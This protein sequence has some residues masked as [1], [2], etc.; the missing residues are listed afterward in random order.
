MN[1]GNPVS[2]EIDTVSFSF[3]SADEVKNLSVKKIT[4]PT[5]FDAMGYPVTNGLYDM[6]LGPLN[7]KYTCKTC[8]LSYHYCPGHFGHIELATP[9]YNVIL[10]KVMYKLLQSTCYCCHKLRAP[11]HTLHFF[12]SKLK[13]IHAGLVLEAEELGLALSIKAI[14]SGKKSYGLNAA[15][16]GSRDDDG[17]V[18][19]EENNDEK[20]D[21]PFLEPEE[22]IAAVD[23]YVAEKFV[24][25]KSSNGKYMTPIKTTLVTDA[26][27]KTEKQLLA[28][29]SSDV[30]PHCR[31]YSPKL[32]SENMQKIF[33]KQI[34]SKQQSQMLARNVSFEPIF[35]NKDINL[36]EISPT[37]E[38]VAERERK[39]GRYIS[40]FEV[41]AHL[42]LLW[43][44]ER[45]ILDLMFGSVSFANMQARSTPFLLKK[46][47]LNMFFVEFLPV[48]PNKFRPISQ[49]NDMVYEHPQNF[50]LSA[51]LRSNERIF[52]LKEG[53]FAVNNLDVSLTLAAIELQGHVNYLFDSAK[54]P[55]VKGKL[56]PPGIRQLLEKKE[57]LFRQNMM[58]KR[59]NYAARSVISPDNNIETNEIGIPPAFAVKLTYPER[60]TSHNY[61]ELARMI[62]N[63][64]HRWPGATH[65]EH[66]N[67]VVVNLELV[68]EADRIA[69]ANSILSRNVQDGFNKANE[70][71]SNKVVR[72][73]L[74]NGDFLLLNRQPTLHKP[75][76][77]AHTARVLPNEK[78]IRMHYANC[79][80]YNAD[81]DGDEMNIHFP[82]ND[83]GRA[84]AMLI[85]R[86]DL[87]YLVPTDGGV[88][89]GLIQDHVDAGVHLTS[90]DTWLTRAQYIQLIY[91][92]LRP[93]GGIGG[94]HGTRGEGNGNIEPILEYGD[95]NGRLLTLEPAMVK[96][97]RM[98]SGKQ[99]I[100]TVLL[101]LT[102]KWMPLNLVG[103]SRVAAKYWG[104]TAPE[105]QQV[106]FCDGYLTTGILD[107]NQFGAS[108]YGLVHA[109]YE[110]Y[111]PRYAGDLLSI[112]GRLF[113]AFL[114]T[115][116]F[117]CRMDDLRLTSQGDKL[118]RKALKNGQNFGENAHRE[119]FKLG[120]TDEVSTRMETAIR[121]DETMAGLDGSMK[122]AMNGLTSDIIATCIPDHLLRQF[123]RNN[124]QTMTVS[125]AKGSNVNVSQISC[126]LGQQELEGRRVPI[127]VSGKSLPSFAPFETAARA[128][129]F[130]S[131][132]FL[133][134]I[135]P[136]E[137][138]FH[139]MAGR[140]GL[141]DTAVKTSRSGYLQRCLI[142]HLEGLRVHYDHTVRDEDGSVYQFL[143]GEDG[144][145]VAL[146]KYLQ[147]FQFS[148]ANFDAF[149]NKLKI[150]EV[151][152]SKH[153]NLNDALKLGKKVSK[154]PAKYDPVISQLSPSR[155]LG[156]A[157]ESFL[158][159]LNEYVKSNPDELTAGDSSINSERYKS[160][161]ILR[162]LRSLVAP[163]EA[164]GL[165]AAQSIGEPSTQMTL[166]TFHFAG[167]GAK[168]VTLGI[169]RLREIIM[170]ASDHIKTP[171]MQL[172]LLPTVGV[173]QAKMI[174]RDLSKLVLSQIV[175]GIKVVNR[176]SC[177]KKAGSDGLWKQI[178]AVRLDL[179][180]ST[181]I[182]EEY[183]ITP[184][185]LEGLLKARF[186]V[187]LEQLIRKELKQPLSAG[188][189]S[190]KRVGKGTDSD[191]SAQ[192]KAESDEAEDAAKLDE[193]Y[194][195]E[196]QLDLEAESQSSSNSDDG[197]SE[198][199]EAIGARSGNSSKMVGKMAYDA[200]DSE[201]EQILKNAN[202]LLNANDDFLGQVEDG[203]EEDWDGQQKQHKESTA[204]DSDLR[205][206]KE[207]MEAGSKVEGVPFSCYIKQF[208][209]SAK[210][211][212]LFVQLEIPASQKKLLMVELA[213][214]ACAR[215]VLHQ[216][217][218][219]EKSYLA[220]NEIESDKELKLM[221]EG[222]N[223]AGMWDMFESFD[224]DRIY[225]N[226]I[227]AVLR[228]FGVEAA[229]G[230]IVREIASVFGVYGIQVDKRHLS[231]IADYMTFEGAYK[232]FNRMGMMSNPSPFTQMSYET[233]AQFLTTATLTG[234]YDN[235]ASPS[236]RIVMGKVVRG[237][238]GSFQ[239]YQP[240][241]PMIE[242]K[243]IHS[244]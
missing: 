19:D 3:Y 65:V 183:K 237:G 61:K 199:E 32:R 140:E 167:F 97:R 214:K 117:T 238:T 89:R 186:A 192:R 182:L 162:Y 215:T 28:S 129:G 227:A 6:A 112:L 99:V 163:G 5:L 85:A 55:M 43:T 113:T 134:G 124:M 105:E 236:A 241:K 201:D 122:S 34:T 198:S 57:G 62:V 205:E 207:L 11:R 91:A 212:S 93:D 202:A 226:D 132:R 166:N 239:V 189:I 84:E 4:N 86:N 228:T 2:K 125:G 116:G 102:K 208:V 196:T 168:N 177:D 47:S 145:D 16:N 204:E 195:T 121:S 75:S 131:D 137:Y 115:F 203:V 180:P 120:P 82:Q 14:R 59:V 100:S 181:D 21:I 169:P 161:M 76:I 173:G 123:P 235:L 50:Y 240:T 27:R 110:L 211:D 58:G 135:R 70:T 54:A 73:H 217:D 63:G 67:G 88:L 68:S 92:G 191:V 200:P 151:V 78:T 144:L 154:K 133:T 216:I 96:P 22:F 90:K 8:H 175:L 232:P 230:A 56:M 51:I 141:I 139:C 225:T 53:S 107:K 126:L 80:T 103:K 83:I 71:S 220:E 127:M 41:K 74:R 72:R 101:N 45:E 40:P 36:D 170:T 23:R 114:Q 158:N 178:Y 106:I 39:E 219:I 234:D 37:L 143:Y 187:V 9:C 155:Y 242:S 194:G 20:R 221:T 94:T 193:A 148:A 42:E 31:G 26:L 156:S 188:D 69:L 138:F 1:V 159:A 18:S 179:W 119:F 10:F 33:Q 231:L 64:P 81:F 25:V 77:M 171:L 160:L 213:E 109:V 150:A 190:S 49:M 224:L 46:S 98:W 24:G 15:K 104:R 38:Q 222:V 13:L 233:T 79:N 209:F 165:L 157:S 35:K 244:G 229:R 29:I 164:V 130:I 153:I 197:D 152:Q 206:I 223:I 176:L 30:C 185:Q 12:A 174:A 52:Q 147:K 172:P 142:K 128:G 243:I 136:Q 108:A 60:V 87:Q 118:R 111:G 210:R 44:R 48:T 66:E 149:V 17:E 184:P 7:E 95:E 146:Q 218:G